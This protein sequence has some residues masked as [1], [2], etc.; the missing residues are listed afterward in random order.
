MVGT[1]FAEHVVAGYKFLMRYY[2]DG[3]HIFFFGFSRGAYTARFLAEM[4]D[5]IGLL[6]SGNEEMVRFAWKTFARWQMRHT[7]GKEEKEK[8]E[9]TFEFMKKFRET[10]SRPVSRIR[11]LGL[12]DTVNSVPL[13]EVA[14]MERSRFP[15]TARTSARVIRHAVSI[16]ER[17][18][19]FRQDL[20]SEHKN[21][22]GPSELS[23]EVPKL[24][25]SHVDEKEQRSDLKKTNSKPKSRSAK[26][27]NTAGGRF[28]PGRRQSAWQTA[29]NHERKFFGHGDN[30][31]EAKKDSHD[32]DETDENLEEDEDKQD[33]EEVWFPG[34]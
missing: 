17:R 4:I 5:Y 9:E 33:I 27:T 28:R 25:E 31:Q 22:S 21:S 32:E 29:S 7:H 2:N 13:F 18:C 6:G 1:S 30:G 24:A 16:D 11:F 15:Y 34:K 26:T 19:K 14:F 23:E 3:D 8:N 12:F 10:F 20:I